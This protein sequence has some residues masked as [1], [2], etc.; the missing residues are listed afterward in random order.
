MGRS[1]RKEN[2]RRDD[3]R[4][5]QR[6]CRRDRANVR[7]LRQRHVVHRGDGG[8]TC[9]CRIRAEI[10]KVPANAARVLHTE[11][12]TNARRALLLAILALTTLLATPAPAAAPS[13]L[14]GVVMRGPITPVCR[15]GVPC[16]APAKDTALVFTRLG[17]SVTTRTDDAGRYRVALAPGAWTVRTGGTRRVGTGISPNV[18]RVLPGRFRVVDLDIDT[19]IR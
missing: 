16:S 5:K 10:R 14:R 18:V 12:V 19:G 1:R 3:E 11:V 17:R 2:A 15:E 7:E 9:L 4:E 8:E 13:G 6:A